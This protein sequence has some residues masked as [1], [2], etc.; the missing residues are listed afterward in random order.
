MIHNLHATSLYVTLHHPTSLYITLHHSTCVMHSP[1]THHRGGRQGLAGTNRVEGRQT[2]L[3]GPTNPLWHASRALM[4]PESPLSRASL[5]SACVS[6]PIP[7]DPVQDCVPG[8][9]THGICAGGACESN[10]IERQ[11]SLP[12][13][14]S[15]GGGGDERGPWYLFV[16]LW[17]RLL[18]SRHCTSRP[19]VGPNVFWLCQRSPRMTYSV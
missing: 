14:V 15:V 4:P 1:G 13:V 19:S 6:G 2:V 10:A 16:C 17:L 5:P 7:L 9:A 18:A 8:A 12:Q 11:R 3:Q